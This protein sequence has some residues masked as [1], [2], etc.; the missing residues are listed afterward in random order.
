LQ[1]TFIPVIGFIYPPFSMD[2]SCTIG[3]RL[4]REFVSYF[5]D[6]AS[7]LRSR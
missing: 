3:V 4:S 2:I 5:G 7:V 1:I 6:E